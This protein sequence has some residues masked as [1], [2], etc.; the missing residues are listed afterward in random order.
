MT[1]TTTLTDSNAETQTEAQIL[2]GDASPI[3]TRLLK[4][5]GHRHR[6]MHNKHKAHGTS[7]DL[8]PELMRSYY[9]WLIAICD[10]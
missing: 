6:H 3:V 4:G 7:N 8:A 5:D 2:D 10:A 9:Q 1:L